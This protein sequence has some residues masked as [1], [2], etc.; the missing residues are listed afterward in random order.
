MEVAP[1][2]LTC[3][4]GISIEAKKNVKYHHEATKSAKFIKKIEYFFI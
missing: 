3:C 1:E 2:A 4:F